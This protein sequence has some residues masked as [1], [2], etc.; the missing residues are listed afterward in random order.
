MGGQRVKLSYG[1]QL[2]E[3]AREG[4]RVKGE[5]VNLLNTPQF[6]DPNPDL[7]SPAFGRITNTLNDGRN[8]LFTVQIQF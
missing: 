5:A 7:S 4:A 2:V 1:I 6:A 3:G 8:L